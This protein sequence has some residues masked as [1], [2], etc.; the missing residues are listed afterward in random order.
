MGVYPFESLEE[1][2]SKKL[3]SFLKSAR[4]NY[5]VAVNDIVYKPGVSPLELITWKTAR[6]IGQFFTTISTQVRKRIKNKKL[7]KIQRY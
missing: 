7:I 4:Y 5:E 1:N 2:S 6:K 3:N